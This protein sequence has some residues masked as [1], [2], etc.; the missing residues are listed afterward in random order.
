VDEV[1]GSRSTGT[2]YASS[3][4]HSYMEKPAVL[5]RLKTRF[6]HGRSCLTRLPI[7]WK[8]FSVSTLSASASLTAPDRLFT[9]PTMMS[10]RA[11]L[12]RACRFTFAV[13]CH[14]MLCVARTTLCALPFFAARIALLVRIRLGPRTCFVGVHLRGRGARDGAFA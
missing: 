5:F 4:K 13:R 2:W 3:G 1:C 9:L 12:R 14:S 11:Y 7:S 10:F 8:N 6:H